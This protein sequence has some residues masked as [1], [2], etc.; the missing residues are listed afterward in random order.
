MWVRLTL[1]TR[2]SART[3]KLETFLVS[4]RDSNAITNATNEL[5][6]V[7]ILIGDFVDVMRKGGN[8]VN[9][10]VVSSPV[11]RHMLIVVLLAKHALDRLLVS[12]IRTH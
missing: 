10:V 11:H 4:Q 6:R 7:L 9:R 3:V 5:K 8:Y 2:R 1:N 12:S